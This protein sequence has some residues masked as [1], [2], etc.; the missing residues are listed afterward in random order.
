MTEG[1]PQ[2]AAP[3]SS[4]LRVVGALVFIVIAIGIVYWMIQ[5][6]S[7]KPQ[8]GFDASQRVFIDS[9]TLK[10]FNYE[11]KLND[12]VPVSSPFS[13]KKTGYPAEMCYWTKDGTI[14][15][16]PTPVLLNEAVGKPG[17]TFCPDCGRL[18]TAH[19]PPPQT[20]ATPPPTRDEYVPPTTEPTTNPTTNTSRDRG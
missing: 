5:N 13:G 7:G 17:P 10:P 9:E 12:T 14:K 15:E 18:V 16:E 11:L 6:F 2:P 1:A 3:K 19:N 8:S 20:G 4:P